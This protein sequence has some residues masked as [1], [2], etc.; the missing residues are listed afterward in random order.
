MNKK[1][2][3]GILLTLAGIGIP[4]VLFF[5][6]TDD[7]FLRLARKPTL[8]MQLHELEGDTLR[9]LLNINVA[10]NGLSVA[11]KEKEKKGL[12]DNEL[13]IYEMASYLKKKID[14]LYSKLGIQLSDNGGIVLPDGGKIAPPPPGFELELQPPQVLIDIPYRYSL[15]VG[16]LFLLAGLA[17]ILFSFSLKRKTEETRKPETP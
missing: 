5:F 10:I 4:L 1:R 17:F 6:K 9:A 16:V 2:K 15:G 12:T 3:I 14:E 11:I 13:T 8:K 7:N